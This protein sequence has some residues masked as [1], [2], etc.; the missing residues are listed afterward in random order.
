MIPQDPNRVW[1]HV[2]A[3]NSDSPLHSYT[4]QESDHV[5]PILAVTSLSDS[6]GGEPDSIMPSPDPTPVVSILMSIHDMAD[7][8]GWSVR[9]VM[10]QTFTRWELLIGDDGSGDESLKEAYSIHDNRIRVF[11]QPHNR[12][13]AAMMNKLLGEAKGRYVLELDGD[14]WLTPGSLAALVLQLERS[15]ESGMAT[16]QYGL[17]ERSKQ[18]GPRWRGVVAGPLSEGLAHHLSERE[19]LTARPIVPRMY[20]RSA[21]VA[22]GGWWKR[23]DAYGRIFEDIELTARILKQYRLLVS[24]ALVYHRV[25]YSGS[26]SQRNR[27]LFKEWQHRVNQGFNSLSTLE[28][29]GGG[30]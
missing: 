1:N 9:S 15:T 11:T 16:G 30:T 7:T 27:H 8:L 5:R 24:P 26:I 6:D 25:I 22:V 29:E 17:W 23:E 4:A 2:V 10:A 18:V 19:P 12:G 14:D 20:R 3:T 28:H 13:K 21:L